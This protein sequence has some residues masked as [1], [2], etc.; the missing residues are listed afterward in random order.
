MPS[1]VQVSCA[2]IFVGVS[3]ATNKPSIHIVIVSRLHEGIY[4]SIHEPQALVP[5]HLDIQEH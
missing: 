3:I 1:N 4:K 5:G 2:L